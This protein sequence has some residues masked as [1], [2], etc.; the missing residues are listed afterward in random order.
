LVIHMKTVE[1]M[2]IKSPQ[3]ILLLRA[4]RVIE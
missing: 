2:G 1:A 3:Y 4:D